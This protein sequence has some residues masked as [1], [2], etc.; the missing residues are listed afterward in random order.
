MPRV[1]ALDK[2]LAQAKKYAGG[3]L[4]ESR[5]NPESHTSFP[6]GMLNSPTPGRADK[7]PVSVA[8]GSY[9]LPADTVSAIGDGNTLSGNEILKHVLHH[10]RLGA[11]LP[12]SLHL[13]RPKRIRMRSARTIG[14]ADGGGLMEQIPI[15]V[16]GGEF[17]VPPE[18]VLNIGGGDLT[19]GHDALDKFVLKT[20]RELRK[21]LAGLPSPKTD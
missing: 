6:S 12:G 3:A 10:A 19:A 20:R 21:K 1:I 13:P 5:L 15:V 17:V 11:G 16:S 7:L 14:M 4:D 18:D 9:I 2:A 8:P